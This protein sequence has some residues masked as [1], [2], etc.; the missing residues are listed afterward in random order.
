MFVTFFNALTFVL[1]NT[2]LDNTNHTEF[3]QGYLYFL[4]GHSLTFL[5]KFKLCKGK[6]GV[7]AGTSLSPIVEKMENEIVAVVRECPHDI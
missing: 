2:V 5:Q 1:I 4:L 3:S 6:P 7:T